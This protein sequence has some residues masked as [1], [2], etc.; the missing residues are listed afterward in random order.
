MAKPDPALLVDVVA[1]VV[2]EAMKLASEAL[3]AA[4]VRHVVVG[5]LAVG[6]NG[7]LRRDVRRVRAIRRS[8]TGLSFTLGEPDGEYASTEGGDAPLKERQIPAQ[9]FVCMRR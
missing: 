4:S 8:G 6:A 1:P 3:A 7:T 9:S 2:L 5:G